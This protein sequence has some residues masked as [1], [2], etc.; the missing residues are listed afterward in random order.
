MTKLLTG[1]VAA[2]LVALT[3]L[4][5]GLLL[6]RRIR[7]RN[8]RFLVGLVGLVATC[9]GLHLLVEP[10]GLSWLVDVVGMALCLAAMAMFERLVRQHHNAELALRLSE[11]RE[12]Q[13]QNF[14]RIEAVNLPVQPSVDVPRTLLDAAPMAMFSVTLDG[15][16]NFWN[17]S[18]ERVFGWSSKEVLGNRLPNLIANADVGVLESE[19]LRLVGKDGA[20]I[21]GPVQS[22]PVRDPRGGVGAI[23]T[24]VNPNTV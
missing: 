21:Q 11:A 15:S 7:E 2:V 12:G 20:E 6:L 19:P 23:L 22:V 17:A 8:P 1:H 24:I 18:A 16:V 9:H 14:Q 5:W 10:I 4:G 3:V 13:P